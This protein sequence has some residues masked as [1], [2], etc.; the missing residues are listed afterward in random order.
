MTCMKEATVNQELN[1]PLLD[2]SYWDPAV[3]GVVDDSLLARP[4]PMGSGVWLNL[5]ELHGFVFLWAHHC[6]QEG[7]HGSGVLC[8]TQKLGLSRADP[9]LTK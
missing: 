8:S 6:L 3:E 5:N 1:V 7:P 4:S 9:R 2:Y